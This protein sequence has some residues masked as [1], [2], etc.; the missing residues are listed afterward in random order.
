MRKVT[1]QSYES[2]LLGIVPRLTGMW[3]VD[4]GSVWKDEPLEGLRATDVTLDLL[5]RTKALLG[6]GRYWCGE[7]LAMTSSGER[8]DPFSEQAF[9][10][11]LLGAAVRARW[12][13]R[14]IIANAEI[15]PAHIQQVM[16]AIHDVVED[17]RGGSAES[18]F[19]CGIVDGMIEAL[20]TWRVEQLALIQVAEMN[21]AA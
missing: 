4:L 1:S 20:E 13:M 18:N 3:L 9:C 17:L 2:Q 15:N 11:S 16:N 7:S 10:F 5:D 12:E 19:A 21:N 8:C 6:D 14:E